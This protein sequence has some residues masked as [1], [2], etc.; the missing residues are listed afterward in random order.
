MCVFPVLKLTR[1]VV[2]SR[3]REMFRYADDN[4]RSLYIIASLVFLKGLWETS[5][6]VFLNFSH[7]RMCSKL[8]TQQ[9]LHSER[10]KTPKTKNVM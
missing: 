3:E 10:K 5:D 7:I 8:K 2:T 9:P 4:S 6:S 1:L